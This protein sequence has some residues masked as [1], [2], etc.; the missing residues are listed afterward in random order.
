MRSEKQDQDD[1]FQGMMAMTQAHIESVR[2]NNEQTA[3]IT[4]LRIRQLENEIERRERD[5]KRLQGQLSRARS[6]GKK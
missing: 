1:Q 2:F 4:N 6:Q 5:N 3:N